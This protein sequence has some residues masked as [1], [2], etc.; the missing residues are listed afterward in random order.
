MTEI[1][2]KKEIY[3]RVWTSNQ[4]Y[5]NLTKTEW[6]DFDKEKLQL[7]RTNGPAIEIEVNN[8]RTTSWYKNGLLHREGGPAVEWPN[9]LKAWWQNGE[10]HRSCGPAIEWPDGEREWWINGRLLNQ[11]EVENWLQENQIDLSTCEGQIAFKLRWQ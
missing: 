6:D 4:N 2:N 11:D 9:G 5:L 10:F 8:T 1:I 7:H 3:C